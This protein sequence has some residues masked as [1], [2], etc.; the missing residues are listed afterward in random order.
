MPRIRRIIVVG[1]GLHVMCRGNG[2]QFVFHCW[3]DKRHYYKLLLEH[4]ANNF[5]KILHY[6]LMNNHVH[7]LLW[8]QMESNVALFMQKV[9]LSYMQYFRKRYGL[10]GHLWQ[11]RYKSII[12]D[13]ENYLVQCGK[14]VELN[15]VRGELV[16]YPE[17]YGFSSYN[18]YAAGKKDPLVSMDPLYERLGSDPAARQRTYSDF[19]LDS[20]VMNQKSFSRRT[21]LGSEDF[22]ER[23]KEK[24]KQLPLDQMV[25][26][27]P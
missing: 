8:P 9:N 12:V 6:C 26:G 15:P 20:R 13:S 4:R 22:V 3:E 17:E 14:Y 27:V 11:G 19:V 7:L 2:K 23:M 5:I 18:V 1:A 25:C 24:I 10:I 16:S 21:I